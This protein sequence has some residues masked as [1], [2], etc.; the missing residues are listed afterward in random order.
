MVQKT[1]KKGFHQN[2]DL[3]APATMKR[4]I[5]MNMLVISSELSSNENR[6]E[7]GNRAKKIT[8]KNGCHGEVSKSWGEGKF[9]PDRFSL[10]VLFI[11]DRFSC[12]IR[13]IIQGGLKASIIHK[14][15][16]TLRQLL[17][18]SRMYDSNCTNNN[19]YIPC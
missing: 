6:Q 15:T 17:V 1:C 7:P 3:D 5:M 9:I 16:R 8:F 18:K 10:M 19:N 11:N 2:Q 13:R 14:P 12:W 4:K